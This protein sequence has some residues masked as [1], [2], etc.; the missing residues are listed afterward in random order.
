MLRPSLF[1]L[2]LRLW[3]SK[4]VD[5][6]LYAH[7]LNSILQN[8]WSMLQPFCFFFAPTGERLDTYSVYAVYSVTSEGAATIGPRYLFTPFGETVDFYPFLFST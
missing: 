8:L 1:F 2:S 7:F 5:C 3:N 4:V 6:F